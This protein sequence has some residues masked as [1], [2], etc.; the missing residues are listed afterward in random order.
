MMCEDQ[1]IW[2]DSN[3]CREKSLWEIAPHVPL[4]LAKL[5]YTQLFL[6]QAV[7]PHSHSM[8]YFMIMSLCISHCCNRARQMQEI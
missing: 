7:V 8:L 5:C 4:K 1:R 3:N 6:P 2:R